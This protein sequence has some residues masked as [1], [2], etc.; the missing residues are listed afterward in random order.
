MKRTIED[1]LRQVEDK[2]ALLRHFANSSSLAEEDA[3]D[4]A[5]LSGLGDACEEIEIRVRT[6]RKKLDAESLGIEVDVRGT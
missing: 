3:P 1:V 6:I 2:A 5:T 4:P